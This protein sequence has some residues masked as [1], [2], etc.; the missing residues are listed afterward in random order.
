MGSGQPRSSDNVCMRPT[1]AAAEGDCGVRS[2]R[3][4]TGSGRERYPLEQVL[5][6]MGSCAPCRRRPLPSWAECLSESNHPVHR[7]RRHVKAHNS[8]GAT[9][10]PELRAGPRPHVDPNI[11]LSVFDAPSICAVDGLRLRTRSQHPGLSS[12]ETA[13]GPRGVLVTVTVGACP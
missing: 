1:T 10:R 3:A 8:N 9:P 5:R 7:A 11:K 2:S 12:A 13:I 4:T 6:R